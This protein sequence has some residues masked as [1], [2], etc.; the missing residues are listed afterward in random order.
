MRLLAV[1]WG[2]ICNKESQFTKGYTNIKW[3]WAEHFGGNK[4][5]LGE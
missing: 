4:E 1:E 2:G 5:Y 3:S